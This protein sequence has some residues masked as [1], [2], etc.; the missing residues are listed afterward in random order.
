MKSAKPWET[1]WHQISAPNNDK[2]VRLTPPSGLLSIADVVIAWRCSLVA[3]QM[4]AN[5]TF[6]PCRP[7]RSMSGL[8]G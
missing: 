5:D 2:L 3:L 1:T 7:R 8:R 4:V 6:L